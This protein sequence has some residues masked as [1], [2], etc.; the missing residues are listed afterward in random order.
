[1]S[2]AAHRV[3][4]GFTLIELVVAMIISCILVLAAGT[5]LASGHRTWNRIYDSANKSIK[6]DAVAAVGAFNAMGRKSDGGSYVL[7]GPSGRIGRTPMAT[8]MVLD[9]EV[10]FKYWSYARDGRN[11]PR[12][13]ITPTHYARFYFDRVNKQLK[14]E[15]G[16]LM[17][18]E[19]EDYTQV[20]AENVTV[21]EFAHVTTRGIGHKCVRM[22][23][24][25]Q[26]PCD[27]E[28][29]EVETAS[30]LRN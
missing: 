5:L 27:G 11:K 2:C 28:I 14:V 6:A 7:T 25:L 10:E 26:D 3:R 29:L 13:S 1:M 17:P 9:D 20:L 12:P 18:A 21:C 22:N 8:V 16:R 4:G 24:T 15:H 30:L 23:L 19:T